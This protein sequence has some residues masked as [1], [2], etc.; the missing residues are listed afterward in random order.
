MTN[1][2]SECWTGFGRRYLRPVV[3]VPEGRIDRQ[4]GEVLP[5][6]LRHVTDHL[7]H[8]VR[9]ELACRDVGG[10]VPGGRGTRTSGISLTC[11]GSCFKH[12]MKGA[13]LIS[14]CRDTK[15]W[16]TLTDAYS[17]HLLSSVNM[18]MTAGSKTDY[19][20]FNGS[21]SGGFLRVFGIKR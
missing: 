13:R 5:D 7:D 3:V 20:M 21:E 6:G 14:C 9:R 1:V 19:L 12:G 18:Q 17:P 11:L 2:F 10:A 4:V 15:G 16:Q 8:R